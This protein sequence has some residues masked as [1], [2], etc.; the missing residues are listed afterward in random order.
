MHRRCSQCLLDVICGGVAESEGY[1]IRTPYHLHAARRRRGKLEG[2]WVALIGAHKG[3]WLVEEEPAANR[4]APIATEITLGS[5]MNLRCLG[6]GFLAGLALAG[7]VAGAAYWRG[8]THSEPAVPARVA[9]ELRNAKTEAMPSAPLKYFPGAKQKLSLTEAI[10]NDPKQIV[11]AATKLD[12]SDRPRTV[13]AVADTASGVTS[14]YVRN[15]PLPW[16]R[17]ERALD[18]GLHY[19]VREDGTPSYRASIRY[20]AL[21]I[22]AAHVGVIGSLEEG[23][24]FVGVGVTVRW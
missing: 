4:C 23:R 15:D 20:D 2:C 19:G 18:L 9:P 12:I 3:W 5:R 24:S 8:L 14:L 17:R 13:T 1:W 11:V 6:V 21:Q 22:K 16:L 10:Q 7:S